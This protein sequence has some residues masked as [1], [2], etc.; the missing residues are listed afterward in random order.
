MSN[1]GFESSALHPH[2]L[3]RW[4]DD[5]Y[6]SVPLWPKLPEESPDPLE[7]CINFM[8]QPL[9][10]RSPNLVKI[11]VVGMHHFAEL[12]EVD[13]TIDLA[14]QLEH[15][16]PSQ[17]ITELHPVAH[18]P[19]F[20]SEA[21]QQMFIVQMRSDQH[22]QH[23]RHQ[24][25]VL[26]LVTLTQDEPSRH[27]QLNVHWSPPHMTRNGLLVLLQLKHF[28]DQADVLCWMYLNHQLMPLDGHELFELA[29]GDHVR[30]QIR[31]ARHSVCHYLVVSPPQSGREDVDAAT[32][33][34][35]PYTVRNR[36]RE[37]ADLDHEHSDSPSLLQLNVQKAKQRLRISPHRGG[38]PHPEQPLRNG[39]V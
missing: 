20:K 30:I 35:S 22:Q 34:L 27:E 29:H 17:D 16:W 10:S 6:D 9:P 13:A 3:D 18:P 23:P 1:D 11:R 19:S 24:E 32:S 14:T 21:P 36:S 33:S 28:F 39:A 15:L 25:D 7:D 12:I 31:S 37:R 26:I 38:Q 2:V 5:W 8:Q 4:C